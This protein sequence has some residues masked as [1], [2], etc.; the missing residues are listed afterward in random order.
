[1][2]YI[3]V[4]LT[5]DDLKVIDSALSARLRRKQEPT[6]HRRLTEALERVREALWE[7]ENN[8]A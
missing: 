5:P 4:S 1:M 7:W 3:D 2:E 6:D 8:N